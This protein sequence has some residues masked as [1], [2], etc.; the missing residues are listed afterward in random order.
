MDE[1]QTSVYRKCGQS[2]CVIACCLSLEH[3]LESRDALGMLPCC[4]SNENKCLEIATVAKSVIH[5]AVVFEIC[6]SHMLSVLK[7]FT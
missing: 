4:L 3:K 1:N 5:F 6:S 7:P 2:Y